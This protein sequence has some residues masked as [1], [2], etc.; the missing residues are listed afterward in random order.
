VSTSKPVSVGYFL[1]TGIYLKTIDQRS[2]LNKNTLK[3]PSSPKL[4]INNLLSIQRLLLYRMAF[5]LNMNVEH[6]TS[7]VQCRIKT[8]IQ[9]QKFNI[10]YPFNHAKAWLY[11]RCS[12]FFFKWSFPTSRVKNN[13]VLISP[14]F[15][16]GEKAPNVPKES[17][18]ANPFIIWQN[19]KQTI[20]LSLNKASA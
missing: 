10:F 20:A 5:S 2:Y 4:A 9:C 11:V 8:K 14:S 13:L 17:G 15:F 7:N 1:N 16:A 3:N 6:R 18:L 12:M 19:S